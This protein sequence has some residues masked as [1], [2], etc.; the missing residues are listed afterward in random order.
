MCRNV[1][2]LTSVKSL[3]S[4]T[5]FLLIMW[6]ISHCGLMK[7]LIKMMSLFSHRIKVDW[8]MII[9]TLGGK[10]LNWIK[11]W[12]ISPCTFPF[13]AVTMLMS[14]LGCVAVIWVDHTSFLHPVSNTQTHLEYLLFFVYLP[15]FPWCLFPNT[16]WNYSEWSHWISLFVRITAW[17]A[18]EGAA[19]LTQRPTL[20]YESKHRLM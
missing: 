11:S 14:G 10:S 19:V 17:Q 8:I 6:E 3:F 13:T 16:T 20:M 4:D 2:I 9:I 5:L 18:E 12:L 15:L 7:S 1:V